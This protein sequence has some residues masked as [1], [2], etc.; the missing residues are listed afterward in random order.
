MTDDPTGA[1]AAMRPVVERWNPAGASGNVEEGEF[2]SAAKVLVI[3]LPRCGREEVEQ[4][5]RS[6]AGYV[7]VECATD[8]IIV[9]LVIDA[10]SVI[11]R[12]ELELL[13]EAGVGGVPLA[14]VL[15]RVDVYPDWESVRVRD[16]GILAAH[17]DVYGAAAVIDLSEHDGAA[18]LFAVVDAV[19]LRAVSQPGGE[20]IA[21]TRRMIDLE[22]RNLRENVPGVELRSERAQLLT[23]RDGRRSERLAQM[24]SRLQR[25][26]GDLTQQ[27]ADTTRTTVASARIWI[28]ESVRAELLSLP[29]R[30][31]HE[32]AS[33]TIIFDAAMSTAVGLGEAGGHL[34]VPRFPD[35]PAAR[36]R[37]NE[38]RITVLVGASAGLGLG[39]IAVTPLEMIPALDIASIPVTLA[40]GGVAAWWLSRARGVAADRAH[41]RAWLVE[42]M[43]T[44][45]AQWEQRVLNGLLDAEVDLGN[46]IMAE[47]REL[48]ASAQARIVE[49]DAELRT[50]SQAHTGQLA[51]CE[52]DLAVLN[53]SGP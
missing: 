52:R 16:L 11:G 43:S 47:S 35:G 32:V 48:I 21:E 53:G 29:E 14:V 41:A 9:L 22:I 18:S 34:P 49:I 40:L 33:D 8:A 4:L 46:A 2:S 44:V 15:T 30:L 37:G 13:D 24:R 27:I 42:T 25:A 20:V 51:A 50:L 3:G 28:D 23:E 17:S 6:R 31:E 1:S 39:R 26:R 45:R 36:P 5:L 10:A 7:T 12:E 19:R 38:E